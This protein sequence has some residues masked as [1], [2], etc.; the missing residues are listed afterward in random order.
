[1]RLFPEPWN[2]S[3][4]Y[5]LISIYGVTLAKPQR[6]LLLLQMVSWLTGVKWFK[7]NIYQGVVLVGMLGGLLEASQSDVVG[8]AIA[9]GL[10]AIAALRIGVLINLKSQS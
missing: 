4:Q 1:M 5:I 6:D 9:G 7:P 8:V 3:D 2:Q 10:S